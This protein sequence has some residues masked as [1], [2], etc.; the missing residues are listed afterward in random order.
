MMLSLKGFPGPQHTQ[1]NERAAALA[2]GEASPFFFSGL[3]NPMRTS[4]G[5]KKAKGSHTFSS[6]RTVSR[7]DAHWRRLVAS[8]FRDAS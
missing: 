1:T 8:F 6:S 7:T 5:N 4:R 2:T 3:L